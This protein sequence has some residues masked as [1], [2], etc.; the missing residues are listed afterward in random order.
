[1]QHLKPHFIGKPLNRSPFLFY[2]LVHCGLVSF[3]SRCAVS[4][5]NLVLFYVFFRVCVKHFVTVFKKCYIN[6]P[7]LTLL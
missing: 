5:R 4:Y 7:L 1:M 3:V 6:I 2:V